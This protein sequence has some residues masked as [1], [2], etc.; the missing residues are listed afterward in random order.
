M[1]KNYFSFYQFGEK[2]LFGLML[3]ASWTPAFAG[4]TVNWTFYASYYIFSLRSLRSLR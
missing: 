4:V 2:V 1:K 3:S